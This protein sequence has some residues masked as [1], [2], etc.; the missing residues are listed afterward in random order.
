M[1][2]HDDGVLISSF[3][4]HSSIDVRSTY[5]F[6]MLVVAFQRSLN[7]VPLFLQKSEQNVLDGLQEAQP[8]VHVVQQTQPGSGKT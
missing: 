8:P 5:V 2:N 1:H 4:G 7:V 6:A 3:C